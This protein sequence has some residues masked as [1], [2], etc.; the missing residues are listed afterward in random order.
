MTQAV[1]IA[2]GESSRFWPLNQAVHK[3]QLYL[4]GKPLVYWTIKGLVDQGVKECIVVHNNQSSLPSELS[5][6]ND[7]GAVI[8]FVEQKER[9]GTGNALWLTRDLVKDNFL[10]VWP[11]Q[12]G[13]GFLLPE[14]TA[15]VKQGA[16]LVCVG[17]KTSQPANFGIF[18]FEQ[19]RPVSLVE[20][21]EK[22]NAPSDIRREGIEF[23]CKDFF[24]VYEKLP[25]HH[26]TDMVDALN[27]LFKTKKGEVLIKESLPSLKYPWDAFLTLDAL[28]SSPHFSP[29]IAKSATIGRNVVMRGDISLG[30]HTV[31]GDNTVIEGPCFIGENCSIGANNVIRG[32]VNL[33]KGVRTGA[34]CEIKHSIIQEG[35]HFHSGYVGDSLTGKDCRFGA[36][37]VTANKRFDRTSV[38]AVVNGKKMDTGR[39]SLG[40]VFGDSVHVGIQA[41]TMPG[42]LVGNNVKIGP[43]VAVFSNLGDGTVFKG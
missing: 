36:G 13:A 8:S 39:M 2:A 7:I 40:A 11:G 42:V 22:E 34:F 26:E 25:A 27:I 33:E 16:E 3:S 12:V 6:E 9:L 30:E 24:S 15:L 14:I 17:T 21:P 4:F 23:L 1:I 31:I 19:G 18:E 32:P 38:K 37:F 35:T 20:K 43:H 41:G 5:K 10:V 29:G 28:F